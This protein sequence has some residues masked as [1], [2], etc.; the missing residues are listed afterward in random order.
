MEGGGVTRLELVCCLCSV[1]PFPTARPRK[2]AEDMRQC[3]CNS[4]CAFTHAKGPRG[5]SS[6]CS[7]A[8][9][10]CN[11]TTVSLFWCD[12]L[13]SPTA[14]LW[15][16]LRAAQVPGSVPRPTPHRPRPRPQSAPQLG[17]RGGTSG[18]LPLPHLPQRQPLPPAR[19]AT[20]KGAR[21]CRGRGGPCCPL[22]LTTHT[23]AQW[24]G[25]DMGRR[26]PSLGAHAPPAGAVLR[27]QQP[28]MCAAGHDAALR[29]FAANAAIRGQ[30]YSGTL[31]KGSY[32]VY[33]R[34]ALV[35]APWGGDPVRF[36]VFTR[37]ALVLLSGFLLYLG[38]K[39]H[40]HE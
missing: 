34:A 5:C 28:L 3:Q 13:D 15:H 4:I 22:H 38:N 23:G 26:E 18:C 7:A 1:H 16:R 10:A 27:R 31:N 11:W 21:A 36:T 2:R 20:N 25:C 8:L 17:R 37:Y 24:H 19:V 40:I 35:V 39:P 14:V 12:P 30:R 32:Y 33:A 6:S 29:C 9:D